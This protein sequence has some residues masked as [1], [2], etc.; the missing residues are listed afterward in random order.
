MEAEMDECVSYVQELQ[1]Q[2]EEAARHGDTAAASSW[3]LTDEGLNKWRELL[4][5]VMVTS[6]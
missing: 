2:M 3:L 6:Q 5:Q 4:Q 1:R